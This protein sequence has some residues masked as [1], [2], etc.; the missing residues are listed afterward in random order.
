[1]SFFSAVPL[2]GHFE[3]NDIITGHFGKNDISGVP[4]SLS[5][6]VFVVKSDISWVLVATF[7]NIFSTLGKIPWNVAKRHFEVPRGG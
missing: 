2:L 3:K 5:T 6:A 1:M 7:Q 4:C